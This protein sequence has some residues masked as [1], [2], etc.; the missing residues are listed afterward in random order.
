[1]FPY[2]MY[3]DVQSGM[4]QLYQQ[5]FAVITWTDVDHDH[6]LIKQRYRLFD[7]EV[8]LPEFVCSPGFFSM[9]YGIKWNKK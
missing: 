8:K 1:M 3:R 5:Y 2:K 7:F 4:L 9:I 6:K